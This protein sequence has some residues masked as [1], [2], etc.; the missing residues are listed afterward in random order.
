MCK[1]SWNRNKNISWFQKAKKDLL[2]IAFANTG[3]Q[4]D[5][6]MVKFHNAVIADVAMGCTRW[7]KDETGLAK[8][9]L[10][11]E[12][13]VRQVYLHVVHARFTANVEV[14]VW[15]VTFQ[16][17]PASCRHNAWLSTRCMEHKEICCQK[18]VPKS[19]ESNPPFNRPR[20][21]ELYR[22]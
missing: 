6:M 11:Q 1:T 20:P 4:P 16:T 18:H 14:F 3:A 2:V 17:T 12:R 8:F 21:V 9:K 13:R 7:S 22:N 10:E 19:T 15:H 5:A